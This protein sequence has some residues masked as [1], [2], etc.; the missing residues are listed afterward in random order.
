MATITEL[1]FGYNH[2]IFEAYKNRSRYLCGNKEVRV[3]QSISQCVVAGR[4]SSKEVVQGS[5]LW[6]SISLESSSAFL[7]TSAENLPVRKIYQWSNFRRVSFQPASKR[8][9]LLGYSHF[10]VAA[11]STDPHHLA[12][13]QIRRSSQWEEPQTLKQRQGSQ[14]QLLWRDL[15][16]WKSHMALE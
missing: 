12:H 14:P 13:K 16:H 5:K 6:N 15:A 8:T 11:Q 1:R 3:C 4:E 7:S 2:R 9:P 10:A